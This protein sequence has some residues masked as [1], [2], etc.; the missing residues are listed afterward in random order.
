MPHAPPQPV[1]R[2]NLVQVSILILILT[3]VLQITFKKAVNV[4][5]G[6]IP[7]MSLNLAAG[8]KTLAVT[9]RAVY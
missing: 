5:Q 7:G 8:F 2:K 1:K 4:L 3:F 6:S 9:Y